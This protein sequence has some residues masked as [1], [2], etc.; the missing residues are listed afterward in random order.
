MDSHLKFLNA[1]FSNGLLIETGIDVLYIRS[2]EF[3]DVI[4]HLEHLIDRI[5]RSDNN[6]KLHFPP[7][8]HQMIFEKTDYMRNFPQL[9]GT[10]NVF[11]GCEADHMKLIA[12]NQN[13]SKLV[14]TSN[15]VL[16]PAACYPLYPIVAKRG[17]VT[18]NGGLF[19]L[20]SYCFRHEP[21]KDPMRQQMF[22]MREF[23][24]IGEPND[25]IA[26]RNLWI[27]RSKE[28]MSILELPAH[29]DIAH[30]P[31]F[32]RIG[33]MLGN[34][35]LEQA[36]KLEL[37]I[38]ITSTKNPTACISFNYHLNHFATTWGIT[39]A[40]GTHAHTA[41]IGFGLER[42]ALALFYHHGLDKSLWNS[43]I[44]KV[45]WQ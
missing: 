42:I 28:M 34:N 19:D 4:T 11:C 14:K 36:L 35:Q 31:F 39:F 40:N 22:R 44:K 33:R 15:I 12:S 30:D 32:G 16:T 26:F 13:W 7:G 38:P 9:A 2:E 20:H 27:E 3:E 21:S 41:C 5:S 45:L 1:L 23:V 29:I 43:E 25:V 6:E 18:S 24:R 37:L 10:I 8:M 17:A